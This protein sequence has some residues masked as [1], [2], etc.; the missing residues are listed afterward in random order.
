MKTMDMKQFD[1]YMSDLAEAPDKWGLGA[2]RKVAAHLKREHR[3]S[4][5]AHTTP[6]GMPWKKTF[7]P[8]MPTIGDYAPMILETGQII[9]QT[10]R[11]RR[12]VRAAQAWRKQ[13]GP[14]TKPKK[15]LVRTAGKKRHRARRIFDR[16]VTNVLS[17]KKTTQK[18]RAAGLDTVTALSYGPRHLI[19]GYKAGTDWIQELHFGG[20]YRGEPIPAREIVGM[21]EAD[22]AFI[23]QAYID[24]FYKY[25]ERT[26]QI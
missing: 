3:K 6:T 17:T 5:R 12:G 8:P 13:Y 23:K 4:L 15:A 16:L 25:A 24:A 11:T 26:G 20:T 9:K 14:P 2:N 1:A 18:R 10:I 21:T 22:I 7:V 19:Y